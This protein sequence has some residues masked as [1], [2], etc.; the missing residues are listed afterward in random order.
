MRE[1]SRGW[2]IAL[3]LAA[4]WLDLIL[5]ALIILTLAMSDRALWLVLTVLL[6]YSILGELL[7][8]ASSLVRYCLSP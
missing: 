7:E 6:A 4:E 1:L 8:M 3:T 2:A 5:L